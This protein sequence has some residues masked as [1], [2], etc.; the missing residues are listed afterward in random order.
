MLYVSYHHRR[1]SGRELIMSDGAPFPDHLRRE[2]WYV[3]TTYR[4]VSG[5]TEADIATLGYCDRSGAATFGR[6]VG[7]P[8]LK[9]AG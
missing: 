8:P 6:R 7:A 9:A 3:H 4:T 1:N 5:R 2:D